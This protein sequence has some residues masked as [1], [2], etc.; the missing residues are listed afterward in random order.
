METLLIYLI[1]QDEK[2]N[3]NDTLVNTRSDQSQLLKEAL[4]LKMVETRDNLKAD[5]VLQDSSEEKLKEEVSVKM[6]A[7]LQERQSVE[8]NALLQAMAQ[9]V[10]LLVLF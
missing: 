3:F 5:P 6:M 2:K 7:D 9:S 8:N 4:S 1:F 10:R